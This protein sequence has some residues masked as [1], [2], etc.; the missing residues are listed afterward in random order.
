MKKPTILVVDDELFF[1]RMY[2]ELLS[3]EGYDVESYASGNAALER[4][5]S[6][7]VDILLTDMV[8]PDISGLEVLHLVRNMENPPEVILVTGHATLETAIK[9]L[10]GGARDYLIKPFNP[11][12]LRHVVRSCLD[13]VRLLD[14]NTLLKSQIRLYQKGQNLASYLEIDKLLPQ[15]VNTLLKEVGNGRGFA[16]LLCDGDRLRLAGLEGVDSSPAL[17]LAT[18]IRA[19]LSDLTTV[20][21]LKGSE[22]GKQDEWPDNVQEVCLFP[23]FLSRE[24]KGAIVVFNP[25][26]GE[27]T[28]PLP[29]EN[30][31]FL[32]D[33]AALA[34]ENSLRYQDV[35]QLIY[36]DD[37]TGLFNYRYLQIVLEQEIRRAERFGFKFALVFIDIDHF[38]EVNDTHGHLAGSA[39]LKEV[40]SLLHK[41]VREVDSL[42]RYGGDEFTALL[43]ETDA[44]G[45][46]LV[47]ERIRKLIEENV[48]LKEMGI[49][50]RLTATVGSAIFPDD[51]DDRNSIV[52]LAD[53]AMYEGKK[54]RNVIRG[55]WEIRP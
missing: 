27:L 13:Q 34:F 53:R 50:C 45:A 40:G 49:N 22:L 3:E 17:S 8:M 5:A 35:Q 30:L 21:I 42:F 4:V 31:A 32:S 20:R 7:G 38:K 19:H 44:K 1:R 29:K 41:A 6:G 23:L 55:A 9:A 47:S 52:D 54:T 2:S 28:H 14:E 26:A 48:F 36:I 24:L 43:I 10:K 25:V 51:A 37:L 33:Q 16:M 11:E 12:E 15:A 18:S 46:A 39:A